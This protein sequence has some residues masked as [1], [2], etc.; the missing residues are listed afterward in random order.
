MKIY[1]FHIFKKDEEEKYY[2][3]ERYG[4]SK[5]EVE[6]ILKEIC[7]ENNFT[8]IFVNCQQ[9]KLIE[10]GEKVPVLS[11]FYGIVIRMYFMEN[12]HNKPHIQ[13]IYGEDVASIAFLTGEILDG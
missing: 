6:E 2:N 8:Y 10:K 11:R 9:R 3:F 7:N 12:E 13:A 5:E 4:E 1:K